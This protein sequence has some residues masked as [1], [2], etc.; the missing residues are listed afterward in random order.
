MTATVFDTH[1]ATKTLKKSGVPDKQV[2]AQVEVLTAMTNEL[3]TKQD[4][5]HLEQRIVGKLS[6][7]MWQMQLG[8]AVTV[9]TALF[10]LFRF[11][12]VPLIQGNV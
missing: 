5:M 1:A 7:K 10:G 9:V 6:V 4:L 8:T 3:A 2:D 11:F 12:M